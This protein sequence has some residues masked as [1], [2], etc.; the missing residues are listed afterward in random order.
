MPR[1]CYFLNSK[2]VMVDNCRYE[3]LR[4]LDQSEAHRF[5]GYL[6]RRL[7]LESSDAQEW[8]A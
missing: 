6:E 5:S 2:D 1:I 4:G 7:V 3:A 8:R